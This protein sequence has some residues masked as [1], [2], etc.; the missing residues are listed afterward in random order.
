[1]KFSP[2][3]F[4]DSVH[5]SCVFCSFKCTNVSVMQNI[6]FLVMLGLNLFLMNNL[7]SGKIL[8]VM[9]FVLFYYFKISFHDDI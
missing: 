1:M 4:E 2:S 7:M 6:R 5:F 8:I 9:V 3:M